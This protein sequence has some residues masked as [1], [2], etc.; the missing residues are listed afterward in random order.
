VHACLT[1]TRQGAYALQCQ[2]ASHV[3]THHTS[4]HTPGPSQSTRY[5]VIN[6]VCA[7]P[8]IIAEH[9]VFRYYDATEKER[10][11]PAD[12]L[13]LAHDTATDETTYQTRFLCGPFGPVQA[14]PY[15]LNPKPSVL[16]L[17][18]L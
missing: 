15:T 9:K 1:G 2:H 8:G 5:F 13:L 12:N 4:A 3:H 17:L 10:E 14:R 16:N 7:H 6:S 18:P 11:S